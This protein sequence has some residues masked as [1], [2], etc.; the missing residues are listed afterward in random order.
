MLD[1]N[2]W[3]GSSFN[4]YN[5]AHF[6]NVYLLFMKYCS[7]M[8]SLLPISAS[9]PVLMQFKTV[10]R[11]LTSLYVQGL[12]NSRC[13]LWI[14]RI[15]CR[16][17]KRSQCHFVWRSLNLRKCDFRKWINGSKGSAQTG[18]VPLLTGEEWLRVTLWLKLLQVL[19]QH[20]DIIKSLW[21][22][23]C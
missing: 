13:R 1:S 6:K 10:Q 14:W 16:K 23:G 19:L 11:P 4:H 17:L 3:H 22:C 21:S 20:E 15:K 2:P 12:C 8:F 7:L 18:T 5:C 9:L